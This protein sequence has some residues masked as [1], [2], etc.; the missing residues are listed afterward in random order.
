M[1]NDIVESHGRR[2]RQHRQADGTW[3]ESDFDDGVPAQRAVVENRLD[4]GVVEQSATQGGDH[5]RS[6]DADESIIAQLIQAGVVEF[7]S[8]VTLHLVDVQALRKSQTEHDTLFKV[9]LTIDGLTALPRDVLLLH[10]KPPQPWVGDVPCS[11][12]VIGSRLRV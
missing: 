12:A 7:A 11:Q 1:A 9:L 5:S 3:W 2:T 10:A 8:Q 6:A 4:H